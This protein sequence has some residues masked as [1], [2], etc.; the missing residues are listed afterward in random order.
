[1]PDNIFLSSIV[2]RYAPNYKD[3]RLIINILSDMRTTAIGLDIVEAYT[4]RWLFEVFFQDGKGSE[5]WGKLTKHPGSEG[6]SRSLIL[7]LMVVI[8]A[9]FSISPNWPG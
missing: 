7:S 9:S 3:M 1:M 8:T 2:T 5:G 6:S 4:L